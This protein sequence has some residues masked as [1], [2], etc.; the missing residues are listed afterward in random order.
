LPRLDVESESA[1]S[2]NQWTLRRIHRRHLDEGRLEELMVES[3]KVAVIV[4]GVH[5]EGYRLACAAAERAWDAGAEVRV[6]RLS[7]PNG[8][9]ADRAG[10]SWSELLGE[11]DDVPEA[12]PEDIA[13]ADV[14]FSYRR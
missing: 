4:D 9:G 1:R 13:W 12:R 14:V 11:S 2:S 5:G 3:V 6:R 8:R 10:A 7:A